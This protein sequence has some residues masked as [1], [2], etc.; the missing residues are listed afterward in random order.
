MPLWRRSSYETE[1]RVAMLVAGISLAVFPLAVAADHTL[2]LEPYL[3][4]FCLLGV[5]ALFTRGRARQPSTRPARRSCSLDSAGSIKLW[6]VLPAIAALICCVPAWRRQFRL[7]LIGLALGFVVA[8]AGVLCLRSR[9]PSFTT[10]SARQIHRGT[11]GSGCAHRHPEIGDDQR[12]Q[13]VACINA[14]T[15]LAVGLALWVSRS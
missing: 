7:L 4:S 11:S 14:T 13:W 1:A 12:H 9:M 3:V 6:A 5:I 15:G 2:L 10:C 8:C